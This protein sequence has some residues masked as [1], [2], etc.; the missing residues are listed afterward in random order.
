LGTTPLELRV[1]STSVADGPRSFDVKKEGYA[2]AKLTQGPSEANV[3]KAVS[4]APDSAAHPSSTHKV[5]GVPGVPG[6]KP[7]DLDIRRRR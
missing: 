1:E 4:L 7:G 3:E 6:A 5:P 2:P